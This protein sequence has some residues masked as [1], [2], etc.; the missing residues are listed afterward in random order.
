[1]GASLDADVDHYERFFEQVVLDHPRG[2]G[3]RVIIVQLIHRLLPWRRDP[4]QLVTAL[5][6]LYTRRR[7][8]RINTV[9]ARRSAI[10]SAV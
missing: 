8:I 6:E 5:P 3:G 7:A 10:A 2:K 9:I 4:S 1:M